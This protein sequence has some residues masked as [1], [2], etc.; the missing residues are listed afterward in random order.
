MRRVFSLIFLLLIMVMPVWAQG[1]TPDYTVENIRSEFSA[2]GTQIVVSFE[3]HNVG[4][5]A[6]ESANVSLTVL[7]TGQLI[8]NFELPPMDAN[9]TVG[10]RF[11]FDV[12]AFP[13]DSSQTLQA[14]IELSEE[15]QDA[16]S[17]NTA[18]LCV[19]FTQSATSVAGQC[20]N[21]S[22]NPL[23]FI[24][25]QINIDPNDSEQVLRVVGVGAAVLLLL[26]IVWITMRAATQKTPA[27]GAGRPPYATMG[28]VDTNTVWGRR[29]L[30][31]QHA[32]NDALPT[33]GVEG[34]V[35]ARKLLLGVDN[36]YLSGWRIMALRLSQYDAYGRVTHSQ[37]LAPDGM[38][39]R[40]NRA[41]RSSLS[42]AKNAKLKND[43]KRQRL[44]RQV[45]PIARSLAGKFQ[46]KINNRNAMLPVALDIR[47]EGTHGEVRIVFELFQAQYGVWQQIDGWEPEMMV[48]GKTIYETYTF[49]VFGQLTSESFR[50]FKRRLP[51]DIT[52][53]LVDTVTLS[54]PDQPELAGPP[55]PEQSASDTP[56]QGGSG[57]A[58]VEV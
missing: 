8:Q 31:Q 48:T 12:A 28:H 33:K 49:T 23:G 21:A 14:L 44:S 24:L 41:A 47:L 17:N 40:L 7:E 30:W 50:D 52:R 4:S 45:S 32:Q 46:R 16:R 3:V 36:L 29:Q 27:F 2:G 57:V 1:L 39:K 9:E 10:L 13:T 53:F 42:L 43:Q 20:I 25:R 34:S 5:D 19:T 11:T 37:V 51:E 56:T 54:M 58:P 22:E 15:T 6:T 55:A 35:Y 26:M 18:F 38:I